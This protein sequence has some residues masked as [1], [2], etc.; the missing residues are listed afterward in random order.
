MSRAFVKEDADVPERA[1]RRRS[2]SGLPP[3]AINYMTAR[4]AARLKAEAEERRKS[5]DADSAAEI[6]RI[7]ASAT[8]VEGNAVKDMV[9]FGAT[10]TLQT[11]RDETQTYQIVGVDELGPEPNAVA[12]ISPI[13]RA[14]L[15]AELGD[16]VELPGASAK[17]TIIKIE[18]S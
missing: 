8:I 1:G 11:G 4:G 13:G 5:G 9:T 16:K 12:W 2:A 15:G 18:H 10:V 7:L 3:G 6:E 17:A 14:L